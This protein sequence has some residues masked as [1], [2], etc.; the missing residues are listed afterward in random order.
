MIKRYINRFTKKIIEAEQITIGKLNKRNGI[1]KSDM[2][3]DEE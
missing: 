3:L 1:E 2:N